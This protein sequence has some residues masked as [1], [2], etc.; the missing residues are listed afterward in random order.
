MPRKNNPNQTIENIVS[1]STKL[2]MEK[3][4]EKTSMQEIVDALGMSKGAI[5]HHFSSKE[6]IFNAV[7]KKQSEYANRA[8]YEWIDEMK[9]FTAKEKLIGLFERILKNQKIYLVNNLFVSRIHDPYLLVANMQDN[10]NNRA[11]ILADVMRHG[12]EDGSITTE[13]P[14]ECAEVFLLLINI[15]CDHVIFECDISRLTRRFKLLQQIMK[16]MGADILGNEL[17][18]N[19]IKYSLHQSGTAI[20]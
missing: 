9:G 13:F 20:V 15:W 18:D 14:D 1:V 6:D 19:C 5:F 17:I 11:V 10:V 12:I 3:G 4:F 7:I 2:F 16:Q 8:M